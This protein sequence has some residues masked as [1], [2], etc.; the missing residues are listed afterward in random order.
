MLPNI[1]TSIS[2]EP[3]TGKTH[4]AMTWP[5]PIKVFCFDGRSSQVKDKNFPDKDIEVENFIMPIIESDDD[6]SWAPPIWDDFYTKYKEAVNSG[7]YQTII[8]DTATTAHTILSQAVFEWVKGDAE[9]ERHKLHVNEYHTR[10]L[11]MK[12][13]FDLPKNAGVNL[14][15]I[16]YMGE[17]WTKGSGSKMPEPTGELKIQGWGQTE[18]FADINI[19]MAIKSKAGGT[20]MIATIKSNGFDRDINGKS[21]EDTDYDEIVSL[22]FEEE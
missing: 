4:L 18:G 9:N 10:N 14:V 13:L 7:Q 3:K 19:E 2:G 22:L 12:A 11:L 17:K 6:S 21:F 5:E 1:L 15:M 16:Q 8:V 20:V